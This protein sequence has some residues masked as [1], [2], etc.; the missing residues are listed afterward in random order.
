MRRSVG[1][2]AI[3]L[4]AASALSACGGG[5][6]SGMQPYPPVAEATGTNTGAGTGG[7]TPTGYTVS[8]TVTGLSGTGLVI[9][10]NGS[11]DLA[12]ASDGP[13]TF[14]NPVAS[15][16]SYVVTVKN[17]PTAYRE[18]CGLSNGSGTVAEA[19]IGNVTIDCST[20]VGFL[21]VGDGSSNAIISYGISAGTGA[22]VAFGTPLA[23]ASSPSAMVRSPDGAFLYV[24]NQES[25]GISIYAVDSA[26]GALTASGSLATPG[27]VPVRMVM[28]P[29]GFLFVC[30]GAE[31]APGMAWS[32]F[33]LSTYAVDASSGALTATGTALTVDPTVTTGI[34][35]T[36]DGKR[37]Y[38][39]SGDLSSN[40]PSSVTVTAYAIDPTTGALTAGP[41]L[42]TTSAY[43]NSNTMA[44]DPLGRYLY[45]TSSQTT[46][47]LAAATV[48]PYAID[49]DTGALTPIGTGTAVAS[50]AGALVVDPSGRYLYM[51]NNFNLD[52]T[53][54]GVLALA[55]DQ[56]SGIVTPIGAQVPVSGWPGGILC[57]P[58]GQFV[59]VANDGPAGT[60]TTWNA[61]AAFAISTDA[62]SAGQLVASGGDMP[63]N[64]LISVSMAVVE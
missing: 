4:A 55:I 30:L 18:I 52:A 28:S 19:N 22:P 38:V 10:I 34:V 6:P 37:L 58:S 3:I 14:A 45:L 8:G 36:T 63:G 29:A 59:Y 27:L 40:T 12:V 5:G 61:L 23:T 56:S 9:E 50:N 25:S 43:L 39:L 48:L 31:V 33:S 32:E 54:D 24:S 17:Q 11:E 60:Q 1:R 64:P 15:G 20:V 44:I 62:A 42:R 21:Y 13:F 35:A 51:I 7:S 47:M 49:P 16:S 2:G 26:S 53:A 57:D 41:V 46:P